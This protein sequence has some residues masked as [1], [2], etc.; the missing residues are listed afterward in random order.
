LGHCIQSPYQGSALRRISHNSA[1]RVEPRG[2]RLLERTDGRIRISARFE[3][4]ATQIPRRFSG[5]RI[6][7]L[8]STRDSGKDR[9][10]S[11]SWRVAKSS[12]CVH[13]AAKA[14]HVRIAHIWKPRLLPRRRLP[15]SPQHPSASKNWRH[16]RDSG[17]LLFL[18]LSGAAPSVG[19]R[20]WP[21]AWCN[22]FANS[23]ARFQ[24]RNPAAIWCRRP[25]LSTVK[26]SRCRSSPA[27]TPEPMTGQRGGVLR[28]SK[29]S[30]Q[31]HAAAVRPDRIYALEQAGKYN[32][33]FTVRIL[34][35]MR[36]IPITRRSASARSN[37]GEV[38]LRAA[39]RPRKRIILLYF[40]S[41]NTQGCHFF[42]ADFG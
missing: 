17:G 23:G 37:P 13:G 35:S 3:G 5:S 14:K 22:K 32:A 30:P 26:P 27:K 2:G 20:I 15:A 33:R 24:P 34:H 25:T 29:P 41:L 40:S 8:S 36:S 42:G 7:F 21:A 39:L 38:A 10:S 11:G 1:R 6:I 31:K 9:F 4:Y 16:T 12:N 28:K 18:P 19:G